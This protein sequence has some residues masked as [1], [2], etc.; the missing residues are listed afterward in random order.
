MKS[1]VLLTTL[2]LTFTVH[3][4]PT[5]EQ[6]N[7]AL[8][9]RQLNQMES[10]L[11]R[12]QAEALLSSGERFHFDYAHAFADIRAMRSGIRDYLSPPRAQPR[13]ISML[14]GLYR[15]EVPHD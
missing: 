12:A 15:R 13:N 4:A 6:A 10:T 5:S 1:I 14:S 8:L 7:L 9:T 3:A 11:R 2:V